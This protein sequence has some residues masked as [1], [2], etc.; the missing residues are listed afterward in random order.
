MSMKPTGQW[1]PHWFCEHTRD[2]SKMVGVAL[3]FWCDCAGQSTV[4]QSEKCRETLGPSEIPRQGLR[5]LYE[6]VFFSMQ[7]KILLKVMIFRAWGQFNLGRYSV[8]I[9]HVSIISWL[10]PTV[11]LFLRKILP[12]ISNRLWAHSCL[13]SSYY[14]NTWFLVSDLALFCFT[15]VFLGVLSYSTI[16]L[17]PP[18]KVNKL[19]GSWVL[20]SA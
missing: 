16:L 3:G 15:V 17:L 12:S 1:T 8:T 19:P 6:L 14:S 18:E 10:H 4:Q 13:L 7:N 11:G 5:T 2:G 9:C 20:P